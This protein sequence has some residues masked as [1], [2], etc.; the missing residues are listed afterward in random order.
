MKINI[1]SLGKFK[2]NQDYRKIF[3]YY[4]KRIRVKTS[5]IEI[6]TYNTVNKI[7]LEKKEILK[8]IKNNDS[9]VAL[10]ESGENISSL[11]F[12][13][14]IKNKLDSGCKNLNFIIG[15]EIGL[16]KYFAK[17]CRNISMGK[18]T[19]PHLLVRVMLIEQIYR[20]FEIIK[21]SQYHK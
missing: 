18:Q 19:W 3:E 9:V 8:H 17:S 11:D 13:K 2:L 7:S 12:A 15:S 16:D 21:N 4:R 10:N 20:S 1:L 5:L 14:L 6:K